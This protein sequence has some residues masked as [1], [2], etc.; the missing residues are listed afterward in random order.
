[1][2]IFIPSDV[3]ADINNR[4]LFY[5]VRP[6][7]TKSGWVQDNQSF[8]K[9]GLDKQNIKLVEKIK[10]ADVLLIPYPIE[11]YFDNYLIENLIRYNNLCENYNTQP[12][13]YNVTPLNF[14]WLFYTQ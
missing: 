7:Y 13:D 5:L 1:M 14:G 9:W 10:N 2:R 3:T 4:R 8:E 12:A 11:Y 6:F